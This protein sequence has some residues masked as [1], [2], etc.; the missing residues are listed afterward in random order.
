MRALRVTTAYLAACTVFT[1][2]WPIIIEHA[3][4]LLLFAAAAA[5]S[6]YSMVWATRIS[7]TL[8]R[9]HELRTY[10]LLSLIPTGAFGAG[11]TLSTACLHHDT[12]FQRLRLALQLCAA[13]VG[14]A[15]FIALLLPLVMLLTPNS[16][17]TFGLFLLLNYGVMLAVAF[18][19]DH[20]QSL[21][22]AHLTGML[23]ASH[24]QNR[25]TAQVWSTAGFLLLQ[26]LTYLVTLILGFV[27]LPPLL[28]ALQL[29]SAFIHSILPVMRVL[30]LYGVH[31]V[32]VFIVWRTLLHH[33]N[34][35]ADDA[36]MLLAT[37][38]QI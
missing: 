18:Y 12:L 31:E 11:W 37:A 20:I 10:D 30:I 9:E 27:L 35:D 6:I 25:V 26:L 13:A 3:P 14:T 22:L 1:L 16:P 2:A 29:D 15:L 21:T 19:L 8:A 17:V 23:A 34:T 5:N 4:M 36:Q 28:Q 32:M 24:I 33:F 7:S 38:S